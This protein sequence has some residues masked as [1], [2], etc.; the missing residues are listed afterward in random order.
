M[1]DC[2]TALLQMAR[3][4]KMFHSRI[5]VSFTPCM[6][7]V[8]DFVVHT[9]AGNGPSL[10]LERL[11]VEPRPEDGQRRRILRLRLVPPQRP[12]LVAQWVRCQHDGQLQLDGFLQV[13]RRYDEL[14]REGRE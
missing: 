3:L 5:F 12:V 11:L 10:S 8:I 9:P 2:S 14:Q 1:T 7:L 4:K 6:S 13:A